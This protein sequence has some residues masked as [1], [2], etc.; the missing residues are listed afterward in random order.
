MN[1]VLNKVT[2]AVHRYLQEGTRGIDW[3]LMH[4][5]LRLPHHEH[6]PP[7]PTFSSSRNSLSICR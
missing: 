4:S 7:Y 1:D 2:E 5:Q 3:V 6:L